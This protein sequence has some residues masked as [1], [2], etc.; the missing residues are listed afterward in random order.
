MRQLIEIRRIDTRLM[1]QEQRK[2]V[3]DRWMTLHMNCLISGH[4]WLDH[5]WN[6]NVRAWIWGCNK[7]NS[8]RICTTQ[9]DEIWITPNK[10]V[11]TYEALLVTKQLANTKTIVKTVLRDHRKRGKLKL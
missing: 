3:L 6:E 7:C 5:Y 4:S 8:L 11:I 9:C 10:D 1:H 2:E